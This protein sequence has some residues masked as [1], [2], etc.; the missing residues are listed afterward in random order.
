MNGIKNTAHPPIIVFLALLMT[1]LVMR[2]PIT[3]VG[4]VAEELITTLQIGYPAYGF[5]T[6]LPIACF[7]LFCAAAPAMSKRFGL[8][9]TVL[10]CLALIF[11]GAAGRLILSYSVMLAATAL[12][13]IGIA[14]LNVLMPVLLRDYFPNNIALVMGVFTGFI[15]FSGSIGAYFSV[16]LLDAFDSL[17]APLGLWVL[18]AALALGAWFLAPRAKRITVAGGAFQWAL[19]KKPL[20]WAVI[21]VMGMQSLTIYTTVA[22]LP[23]ILSTLGFSASAAGLGS[24]VFLLVS[25]PASILTAAFIK[26]VGGERPASLIMTASFAIGIVL[27][28]LGGT[29]SFVGCVLAGIPQG[30]TFSMA[31]ILMAKKTN[32]LSQLLVISSLAQGIGYVLAGFGPFICGLL[33][34]GDGKWLPVTGFM[35]CAVALWGLSAWYAF[36][37]RKLFD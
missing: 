7:G 5:L 24:A 34:H 31:M 35:L 19:L 29:W 8:L 23:T 26:A 14:V 20:T 2:G 27:W 12:I 11:I 1:I 33:Y 37:D 15:G 9:V 21:F 28:L 16:P 10:I 6:A 4:A 17:D 22:W 3:C 18:M 25:A 30:I 36:G 13:G 32:S